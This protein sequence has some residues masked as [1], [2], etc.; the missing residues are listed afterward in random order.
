M[1]IY[2]DKSKCRSISIFVKF[3]PI[4][5]RSKI[6]RYML[7]WIVINA[8]TQNSPIPGMGSS[9][10]VPIDD[11]L[12]GIIPK[13]INAVIWEVYM[14]GSGVNSSVD[15]SD[16][17]WAWIWR[18]VDMNF[19]VSSDGEYFPRESYCIANFHW[20]RSLCHYFV[21]MAFL[22]EDKLYEVT[23]R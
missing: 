4:W 22:L 7:T 9:V 19:W 8:I 13:R 20:M 16:G 1:W 10:F 5:Q 17:I 6:F 3:K 12:L 18:P 14:S 11:R 15:D 23:K 2:V 21:C